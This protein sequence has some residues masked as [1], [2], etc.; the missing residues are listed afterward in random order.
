MQ[1]RKGF[2]LIELLIVVAIIGILAAL[3]IPNIITAMQKAKQKST[4]K[5]I[6]TI[7][8]ALANYATDNGQVPANS[9]QLT[10]ADDAF[11]ANISPFYVQ[12]P[13]WADEWGHGYYIYTQDTAA[14]NPFNAQIPGDEVGSDSFIVGSSGRNTATTDSGSYTT[15]TPEGGLYVVNSMASFN[16]ELV[17]YN[18]SWIIGPRTRGGALVGTS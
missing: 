12:R 6:A 14:S 2:T 1:K 8:T 18:G 4:M 9:S 10:G 7:S 3:L 15:A 5:G 11:I 13:P 16:N 17:M